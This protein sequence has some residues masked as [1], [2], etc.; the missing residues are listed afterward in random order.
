[1]L[2]FFVVV[3]LCVLG[4]AS[5]S[6]NGTEEARRLQTKS[7]E[8]G[9]GLRAAEPQRKRAAA[10]Y[11][12]LKKLLATIDVKAPSWLEPESWG[13]TDFAKTGPTIFA[14]AMDNTYGPL[15]AEM[16]LGTARKGGFAGEFFVAVL[17]GANPE[18][19]EKLKEYKAVVF[20]VDT[21]CEGKVHDKR[22]SFVGAGDNAAKYSINMIRWHLYQWWGSMLDE[23]AEIMVADFRDVFFQGNPFA[24]R[25]YEWAHPVSQLTVFQEAYPNKVIYR[26]PFNG[27]WIGGCYGEE[28]LKR[29]GN[30]PVSCSG[31][32]LG[33]R[34][35]VI[36]YSHLMTQQLDPRV[37]YGRE[38]TQ[39][40]KQCISLG[41]DQ[42]FHN[43]LV[44]SGQLD[45]YMD[46]KIFSQG[47]GPVNTVGAFFPGPRA[48]LK[49][50]LKTW[51]I[52]KGEGKNK[53]FHNWNGDR[54]PVVHQADRFLNSDLKGGYQ[55]NLDVAQ[56]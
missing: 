25:R 47:E 16:F 33:L 39:T 32:T 27:G 13:K 7:K 52:L 14:A 15:E 18:F 11:E 41:M 53:A 50:D 1:M 45:K 54:S 26:C 37:R 49:F 40:N 56:P 29:I 23:K 19:I 4:G 51:N 46:V 9:Y 28:G 3:A 44:Y 21:S 36:A 55:A 34:D 8:S 42:G 2:Y 20:K 22:C 30:N 24:Y 48:L 10:K 17:S 12:R 5:A 43:W 6:N 38:T 31:V 35:A